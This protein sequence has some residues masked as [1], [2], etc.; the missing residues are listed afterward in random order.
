MKKFTFSIFLLFLS[1]TAFCTTWTIRN[2]GFVF[3]PLTIT[4]TQGDTV[5]FNIEGNHN[6]AEVSQTTWNNNGNTQLVGGFAVQFGG[7]TVLPAQLPAGTH[8]YVCQPHASGGMKG[9]IIVQASTSI[10]DNPFYSSI[11]VYPNPS[12]GRIQLTGIDQLTDN[13]RMEIYDLQG[14]KV[15]T[16]TTNVQTAINRID[17]T[18][19]AA[20]MYVVKIY[21]GT[22][23]LTRRLI[24]Q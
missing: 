7:G 21:D 3:D 9:T 22:A 16:S 1:V 20:G 14:N 15:F 6:A 4:I 24:L 5:I 2:T 12:N 13:A 8:F 18:T 19:C 17:L 23:I 11:S 10:N